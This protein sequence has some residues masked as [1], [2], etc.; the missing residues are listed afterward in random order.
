MRMINL[1][2]IYNVGIDKNFKIHRD[3]AIDKAN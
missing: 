2:T 1:C 3:E